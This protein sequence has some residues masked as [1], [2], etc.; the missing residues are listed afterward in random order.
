MTRVFFAV[1]SALTIFLL[2]GA[3]ASMAMGAGGDHG[4]AV[5]SA[6]PQASGSPAAGKVSAKVDVDVDGHRSGAWYL[7][8]TWIVIGILAIGVLVAIIVAASRGGGTTVIK[9]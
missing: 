8:P 7:S 5:A 9:D 4:T 1:L 3:P 6:D 2:T